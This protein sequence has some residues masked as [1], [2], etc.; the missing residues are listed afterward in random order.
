MKQTKYTFCRICEASCG[1][2]AE[3]E[4]GKIT[5]IA[6][7]PDHIGTNGFACKKGLNQHHIYDSPDRLKY[8]LKRIGDRFERISWDQA[9]QEIGSKVKA[10]RQTSPQSISMYVGTAA[11]FSILHPIFAEGFMQGIGSHNIYTSSTQDCANRFA[12]ASELYGFPFYQ[13]FVDL[14]NVKCMIVVGTNP[15]VSKWTFLQVA[16]PA[17]RIKELNARGARTI[18]VDPRYT[19]SA[20]VGTDHVFIRPNSDVFFFLS[21]LHE[22]I[23][24]EG[25][26]RECVSQYMSGLSDLENLTKHWPAERTEKL[27]CIPA[28]KLKEM[29]H[30]YITSQASAIVTGTGIGMG[31]HGTLAHWLA[32]CINAVSGNLDRK[33]GLLVGQGIFDFGKFA[34]K[35]NLFNRTRRSRIGNFREINGGFPGG[36]LADEILTPGDE[37]IKALFVTG[38]NPLLTMANSARLRN[39]FKELELLVVTDIHLNET[40]SLAH[41]ILPATSPLER[42]DLPFVFPLFMG[43]QS[44]PYLAA[45]EAIVEPSGEQRDEA[46]IY[47][48]LASACGVGLFGTQAG[49]SALRLLKTGNSLFRGNKQP[50]L[51]QKFLM[52]QLLRMNKSGSF[53]AH[54]KNVNGSPWRGAIP[55]TF[56]GKRPTTDDGKVHLAPPLFLM[57]AQTL[58]K[59]FIEE[60]ASLES[61]ELR[62]ISKREHLTHNSWTQNIE[63]LTRGKMG[64]TNYLY[65]H[66]DDAARHHLHDDAIADIH[67]K[68]ACIR[69]PVRLTDDLMPGTVAVPHGWGHQHAQGLTLASR[70]AGAN[71]NLLA[72]DGT[73]AIETLSG[74][75]HLSG[76]PVRIEPA[77]GPLD[78]GSWSG[79]AETGLPEKSGL[80]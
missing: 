56:L 19:E 53:K 78:T 58:E 4:D 40:A 17:Q 37:Q 43:M 70:I 73:E 30:L 1:L 63:E 33:G 54:L 2:I 32:E 55:G 22:L 16:H 74:M 13:P 44:K 9:L 42:P 29:V 31:K 7:N 18:F 11:G 3:L 25:I 15:V 10:L 66:R 12:S 39:A 49:Q 5:S 75:S 47:T 62:L 60:L 26:D 46:T 79:I 72:A 69:L 50:A 6:P 34:Q 35:K 20:K 51:P 67:S 28:A 23:V 24:Q 21:F 76:I 52:D 14:D 45:T 65:M 57:Q 36:I 71:V 68:T 64:Q 80:V 48:D 61:G 59:V 38:G 41:Y 77:N 8:P 27:T